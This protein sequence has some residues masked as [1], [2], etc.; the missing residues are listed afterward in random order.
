[1]RILIFILL[2]LTAKSQNS[3]VFPG[4][5]KPFTIDWS[6]K[7]TLFFGD[8]FTYG[9][10]ASPSSNRWTTLFSTAK[11]TTESNSGVSGQSMQ[12][13]ACSGS[14]FNASVVPTFNSATHCAIFVALGLNDVG[15]NQGT[16]DTTGYG[17]AMRAALN[18]IINTKGWPRYRVIVIGIYWCWAYTGWAGIGGCTITTAPLQRQLDYNTSCQAN[19]AAYGVNYFDTYNYMKANFLV[20]DYNADQLHLN[21]SG[22]SKLANYLI[23][24]IY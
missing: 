7:T 22:H 5:S 11:G 2:S 14:T 21:N 9:V 12:T 15:L 20:T 19:A 10:A 17:T 24:T 18:T 4:I 8:S 3:T 1:M 13:N 6:G 23:S 16:M